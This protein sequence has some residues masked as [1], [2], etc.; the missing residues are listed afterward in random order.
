MSVRA[1][2]ISELLKKNSMTIRPPPH[3]HTHGSDVLGEFYE[4]KAI[5][6]KMVKKKKC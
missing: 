2:F 3:T 1:L 5:W 4:K 6:M